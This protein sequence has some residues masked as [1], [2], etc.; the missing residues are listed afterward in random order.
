MIK[1]T[2]DAIARIEAFLES[3]AKSTNI[4]QELLHAHNDN[5]LRA[6]DLRQL[7]EALTSPIGELFRYSEWLDSESLIVGDAPLTD[8]SG[9]ETGETDDRSHE[10]LVRDYLE[11][12]CS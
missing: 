7:I 3:R 6:S 10:Q 1:Q 8:D 2:T 5:E 12:D 9:N 11:Q 4:D